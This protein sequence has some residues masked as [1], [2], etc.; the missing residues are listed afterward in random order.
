MGANKYVTKKSGSSKWAQELSS[1]NGSCRANRSPFL[2][3]N[4][5]N[6]ERI[7]FEHGPENREMV[8]S[9]RADHHS[10]QASKTDHTQGVVQAA[11]TRGITK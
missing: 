5:S 11:A 1:A 7:G 8:H 9:E 3:I 4:A 2:P 6:G 10:L